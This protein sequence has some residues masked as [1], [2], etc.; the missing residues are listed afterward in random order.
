M[1]NSS[2]NFVFG[3]SLLWL[4]DFLYD[5][6][7]LQ[8]KKD[9]M[10]WKIN[11]LL[12]IILVSWLPKTTKIKLPKGMKLSIKKQKFKAF[13]VPLTWLPHN[14]KVKLP[15]ECII[16]IWPLNY[17]KLDYK[18]KK[19]GQFFYKNNNILLLCQIDFQII[20][21][22]FWCDQFKISCQTKVSLFTESMS[23]LDQNGRIWALGFLARWWEPDKPRPV[24]QNS[25]L[26]N[27]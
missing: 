11:K 2:N 27:V 17:S 24:L 10:K 19:L 14:Y 13:L 15:G 26:V 12:H 7:R 21:N 5:V 20:C 25:L 4:R 3:F 1:P 8:G 18:T 22:L 16:F 6:F 23:V 9:K